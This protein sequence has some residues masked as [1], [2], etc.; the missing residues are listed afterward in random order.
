MRIRHNLK[1]GMLVVNIQVFFKNMIFVKV[2]AIK[3]GTA[4]HVVKPSQE[5]M[6]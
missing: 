6:K 5:E 2:P 1:L 4:R 3:T